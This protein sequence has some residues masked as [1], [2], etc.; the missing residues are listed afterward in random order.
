[1][2]EAFN[3]LISKGDSIDQLI[4]NTNVHS[5]L[6]S[7]CEHTTGHVR[8]YVI[9]ATGNFFD[10]MTMALGVGAFL[11]STVEDLSVEKGPTPPM[12]RR[13]FHRWNFDP[14]MGHRQHLK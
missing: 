2:D 6:S 11:V 10:S 14:L 3:I 12:E 8:S 13:H 4:P 7:L 9:D 1:M 5:H